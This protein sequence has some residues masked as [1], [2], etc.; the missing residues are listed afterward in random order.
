[1]R[2]TDEQAAAIAARGENLLLSAAAGSG[3]TATLVER[4]MQLTMEGADV[5]TMLVVTFTRAAAAG[6]ARIFFL[7]PREKG[8]LAAHKIHVFFA[9][10][11]LNEIHNLAKIFGFF[12]LGF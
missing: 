9:I 4:V 5:D 2:Y 3:K 11:F 10:V 1:M 6:N 12:T 8:I 7:Q